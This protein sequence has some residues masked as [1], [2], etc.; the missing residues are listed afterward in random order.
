MTLKFVKLFPA[1]SVKLVPLLPEL[2]SLL[3]WGSSQLVNVLQIWTQLILEMK[4]QHEEVLLIRKWLII[5]SWWK[6]T[7]SCLIDC[8]FVFNNPLVFKRVLNPSHCHVTFSVSCRY[9]LSLSLR[10]WLWL[11]NSFWPIEWEWV[12]FMS[13]H[14]RR[15]NG[16]R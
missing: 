14:R 13:H 10:F 2:K 5:L 9:F 12:W 1:W 16:Y 8:L 11:C 7:E 4:R 6:N 3:C 15:D